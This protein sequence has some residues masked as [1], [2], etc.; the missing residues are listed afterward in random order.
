MSSRMKVDSSEEGTTCSVSSLA[1]STAKFSTS[2][3]G[4]GVKKPCEAVSGAL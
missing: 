4:R 3:S 1:M 2:T